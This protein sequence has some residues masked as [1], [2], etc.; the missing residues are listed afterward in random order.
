MREQNSYRHKWEAHEPS[1]SLVVVPK[2]RKGALQSV[3]DSVCLVKR[4]LDLLGAEFLQRMVDR[5]VDLERT[6]IIEDGKPGWDSDGMESEES[7]SL[8]WIVHW[9]GYFHQNV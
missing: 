7:S 2:S 6:M 5:G 1:L 4:E 8:G 3:A 9:A